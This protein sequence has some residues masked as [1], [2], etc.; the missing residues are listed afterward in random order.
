MTSPPPPNT[1]RSPGDGG[2][3]GPPQ[4]FGQPYGQQVPQ[5]APGQ[6]GRPY[7]QPGYGAQQPYGGQPGFGQQYGQFAPPMPPPPPPSGGNGAKVA[8][9]VVASVLV[10]GLAVGGVILS[11]SGDKDDKPAARGTSSPS[12]SPSALPSASQDSTG[13]SPGE[14]GAVDGGS[15]AGPSLPSLPRQVPYVVLKPGQCYDH[16]ALSSGVTR[17]ETRSCD[18]AHDGEVVANET[19]TGTFAT[20]RDIQEKAVEL[21]GTEAE[22]RVRSIADGR[23]YY[24]YTLMPAKT[25]YDRGQNQLSCTITLSNARGGA[26]L[27]APLPD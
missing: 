1:P 9:I 8:A 17:V 2:G 21:C 11:R 18:G 6:P 23:R 5:G 22:K 15:S 19:L 4:S 20:Q 7:G 24:S 26:K 10:V 27:T 16:P 13:L 14:G 3:F 12:A 25:T